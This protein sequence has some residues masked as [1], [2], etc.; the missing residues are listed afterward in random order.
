[1][2]ALSETE[3]R[4]FFT[5]EAVKRFLEG[6]QDFDFVS[7]GGWESVLVTRK[8]QPE[9]VI[10]INY[11]NIRPEDQ[12]KIFYNQ[13]VFSTIF[14][15]NFPKF[16]SA[17]VGNIQQ[18]RLGGTIRQRIW[19]TSG[20]P[21]KIIY[22]FSKVEAVLKNV[23]SEVD[24]ETTADNLLIGADGGE[25]FVDTIRPDDVKKLNPEGLLRYMSANNYPDLDQHLVSQAAKRIEE[26]SK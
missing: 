3:Q 21:P 17:F 2:H 1:M 25:Y 5:N 8:G 15:H 11:H 26:L 14:P 12:K 23:G 16:Y 22:P 7:K 20:K 13:R 19:E 10:A 4:R 9:E 6:N 24:F 18:E